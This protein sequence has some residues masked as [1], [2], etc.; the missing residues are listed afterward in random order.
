MII[1]IVAVD[2]NLAIGRGGKIPW[3]YPTDLKFFKRATEDNTVV[4]GRKTWESIG[5]PLPKR[6][7]IILSRTTKIGQLVPFANAKYR[8]VFV[9]DK[10]DDVIKLSKS[11]KK[12]DLY[13]IG[14][15]EIYKQFMS[16]I[17]RWI[18][19]RIPESVEDADTFMPDDFLDGFKQVDMKELHGDLFIEFYERESLDIP[20]ILLT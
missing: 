15:L 17:E 14:G 7:N 20:R 8:N 18:V 9:M 4:M 11:L 3:K 6:L 10:I 12:S 19:S 5:R 1:G 13:I 2:R 16:H